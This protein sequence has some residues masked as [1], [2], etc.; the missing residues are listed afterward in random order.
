MN[1]RKLKIQKVRGID[2]KEFMFDIHPNTPTFFV[3][4]NGFGKTSIATA[5]N[6][7]DKNRL[8]ISDNDFYKNESSQEALIEI[9]DEEGNVYTANNE[10][11]TICDSFSI[12]VIKSQTKPK[13]TVQNFGTFSSPRAALVVEPVILYNK[14]PQKEELAY[15][16]KD[17]KSVLGVSAGKLLINLRE[18]INSNFIKIFY[19]LKSDFDKLL[20]TR[21]RR[22]IETF[23]EKNKFN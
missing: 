5:F 6:S 2:A 11:N 16:I 7:L 15:S 19:S 4:P 10:I 12:C 3:A 23:L 14:V 18:K 1:L 17:M 9:T 22:K 20:Q 21:N 13:A 8:N